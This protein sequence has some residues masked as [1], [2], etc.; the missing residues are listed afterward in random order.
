MLRRLLMRAYDFLQLHWE[1][2]WL[3]RTMGTSAILVFLAGLALTEASRADLFPPAVAPYIPDEPIWAIYFAFFLLLVM[4]VLG[5]VFSLGRSISDTVGKQFEILSLIL[6]RDVFIEFT[7]AGGELKW[8]TIRPEVG[9]MAIDALAATV[10]FVLV[11]IYYRIQRHVPLTTDE[12]ERRKFVNNKKLLGL[13]LLASFFILAGRDFYA[14]VQQVQVSGS[15]AEWWEQHTTTFFAD[16]FTVLIFADVLLVLLAFRYSSTYHIGFRNAGFA[17]S[18]VFIRLALLAETEPYLR[19]AIGVGAAVFAVG[20]TLSYNVFS[21]NLSLQDVKQR[22][23]YMAS[24]IADGSASDK[25]R[26]ETEIDQLRRQLAA[27]EAQL[28]DQEPWNGSHA[29]ATVKEMQE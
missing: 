14:L 2:S 8:E 23:E 20:L 18:T 15:F 7:K 29:N 17:V 24:S 22:M 3:R 19:A 12:K 1:S 26:L 21:P 27:A 4:E 10:I 13:G 28:H 5:L 25:D 9:R 16:L 6:L 11:G